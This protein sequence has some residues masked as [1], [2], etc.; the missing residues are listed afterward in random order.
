MITN[1]RIIELAERFRHRDREVAQVTANLRKFIDTF[2]SAIEAAIDALH[3]EGVTAI[4][5]PERER[6]PEGR[7]QLSFVERDY[8]FLFVPYQGVAFPALG[9]CG[10]LDELLVDELSHKRAGRLIAFHHP[11]RDPDAVK[12]LGSYYVFADASWCVCSAGHAAHRALND[13]EIG[14]YVLRLLSLIQDGLQQHWRDQHEIS[15]SVSDS[16]GP[17]T[18]FHIP[19]VALENDVQLGQ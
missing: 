1:G 11:L 8:R 14:E 4:Q 17:E 3:R 15:F 16:A 9:E 2:F 19:H 5:P 6:L 18:R 12:A 13:G 10:L 7:E